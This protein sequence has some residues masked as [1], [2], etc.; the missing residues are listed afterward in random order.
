MKTCPKC[1]S[2]RVRHSHARTLFEA[3]LR[4]RMGYHFYRCQECNWR[5]K[6][7]AQKKREKFSTKVSIWK[8]LGLYILAAVIILFVVF[9]IVGV[10]GSNPPP[11]Q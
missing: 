11:A 9:V 10:G 6:E 3:F 2:T 1:T 7:S 4:T 5:G 8:V